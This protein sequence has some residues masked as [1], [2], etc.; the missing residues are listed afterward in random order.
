MKRIRKKNDSTSLKTSLR[1]NSFSSVMLDLKIDIS[2]GYS[3]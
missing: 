2:D 3:N 1:F